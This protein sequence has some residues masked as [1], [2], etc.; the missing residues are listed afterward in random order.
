MIRLKKLAIISL[1]CSLTIFGVAAKV[2]EKVTPVKNII[3][4]IPDGTSLSS[5][6]LAR[7]YQRYNNP[8]EIHLNIDPYICGTVLTTSSNAPIGDSAPTTSCYMT[9][10]PSITGFISTY[11][12]SDGDNDLIPLDPT[13]AYRPLA[14]VLEAGK[15]LRDKKSGLVFTCEF[16]HA[17]PADCSAHSYSRKRY[18]VIAPQMVAQDM[19]VVIGGG[20]SILNDDMR[21]T[22]K[23]N[24]YGLFL[25]DL[26]GMRNYK[27]NK[28]WALY[29]DKDIPYDIDRDST[30]TPSLAE[31]TAK[32][33]SMLDYNNEKGFFLMVEGSKVDWAAHANDPVGVATEFLAFDKACKVALDFAR[34][35]GNTA[36]VILSDHGNS[37]L[38]IGKQSYKNYDK[39]SKKQL[40]G[41]LT[42]FK[43]TAAGLTN[44]INKTPLVELNKLFREV[45]GF[46]L[47]KE[48]LDNI[49]NCK[50][51][52]LSTL[53]K[54][55]RKNSDTALYS[56][57]LESYI[58]SLYTDKTSIGF[59]THGHTGEEV[60]LAAYHPRDERPMGMI[61]N[62]EINQYLCK[63]FDIENKLPG[64]TSQI[65]AP[66]DEVFKNCKVEITKPQDK[67][68]KTI[69]RLRVTNGKKSLE[70]RAYTSTVTLRDG[71][72]KPSDIVLKSVIVYVDK[73]NKFYLPKDLVNYLN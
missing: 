19:D 8:Q 42:R 54:E 25:N 37:G 2:P 58:S 71:K 26:N 40:F 36:I 10:I 4:M 68:D 17:T 30:T 56:G 14:T 44:L 39:L 33:I 73:T 41:Q 60:L 6:S 67:K 28:M 62:T 32:A 47:S 38:S 13:L 9:G 50:D 1:S 23:K 34:K 3:L 16:P 46:D 11:P 57:S 48:E 43:Y 61:L 22:L 12:Y 65:F 52:S 66:H 27:G 51:Y 63:L 5:I 70:L 64:L 35:D 31:M 45:C 20:V 18:D 69:P 72:K 24:N 15:I 29:E 21:N 53:S 7:W 55:Q 59:T 49:N